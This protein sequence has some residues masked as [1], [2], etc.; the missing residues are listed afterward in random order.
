MQHF[1]IPSVRTTVEVNGYRVFF[2][3]GGD[4]IVLELDHF[5]VLTIVVMTTQHCECT[6]TQG[7]V[8]F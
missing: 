4:E 3:G 8:H 5:S 2:W 6:E 7:I 1:S